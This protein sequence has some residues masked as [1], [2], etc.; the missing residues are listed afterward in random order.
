MWLP[1]LSTTTARGAENTWSQATAVIF[2]LLMPTLKTISVGKGVGGEQEASYPE[3]CPES[4]GGRE[5][6]AGSRTQKRHWASDG[7]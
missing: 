1:F 6:W 7:T 3:L 5:V 2:T 4:V